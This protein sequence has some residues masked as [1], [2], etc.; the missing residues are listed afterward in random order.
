M[1]SVSLSVWCSIALGSRLRGNDGSGDSELPSTRRI[2]GQQLGSVRGAPL[3]HRLRRS[4]L[5]PAG[6]GVLTA[7]SARGERQLLPSAPWCG[8]S[9]NPAGI[10]AGGVVVSF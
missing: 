6:E 7:G 4:P 8:Q 9:K 10:S 1:G 5:P 3:S 2:A